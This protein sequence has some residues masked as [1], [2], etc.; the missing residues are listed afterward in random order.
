LN[1]ARREF[2][3]RDAILASADKEIFG[4]NVTLAVERAYEQHGNIIV[5]GRVDGNFDKTNL[6]DPVILTY[7]FSIRHDLITQLII[8]LNRV[9]A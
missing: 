3:G 2:V 1:D 8:T 4:D 7:Y 9:V 6:P 5:H